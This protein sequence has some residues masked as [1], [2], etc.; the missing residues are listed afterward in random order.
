QVPGFAIPRSQLALAASGDGG[1]EV[2]ALILPALTLEDLEEEA[3]VASYSAAQLRRKKMLK[4]RIASL[5]AAVLTTKA[6]N[7][8]SKSD[9]A[10]PETRSYPIQ[11]ASHARNALARSAGKPEEARV[12]RAVCRKFP[13]MG[14]CNK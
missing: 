12:R 2:S 9:F 4:S 13:D 7:A 10:I 3:L 1:Y 11:D 14:E 8:L 6:R 5:T